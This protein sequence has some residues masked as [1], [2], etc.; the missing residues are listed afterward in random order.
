MTL[1]IKTTPHRKTHLRLGEFLSQ[2]GHLSKRQVTW[3]LEEQ[4]KTG[5]RLGEILSGLKLISEDLV[6]QSL[7]TLNNIPYATPHT[8]SIDPAVATW[9]SL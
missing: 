3:A 4:K 1:P 8:M 7:S 6:A 5:K 2:R 9:P